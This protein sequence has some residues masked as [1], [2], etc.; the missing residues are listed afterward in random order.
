MRGFP[1]GTE[2]N[3]ELWIF[4][5]NWLVFHLELEE[6]LAPLL[7]AVYR[8]GPLRLASNALPRD[9]LIRCADLC[10]KQKVLS[11]S[12]ANIKCA[13][14]ILILQDLSAETLDLWRCLQPLTSVLAKEKIWYQW[15]AYTWVQ[16]LHKGAWPIDE[17]LES[18]AHLLKNLGL[19]V[20]SD[21]PT[22]DSSADKPPWQT[23][24][25]SDSAFNTYFIFLYLPYKLNVIW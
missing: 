23:A 19:E 9:I 3:M 14:K 10:M 12:R 20:S 22:S 15:S 21:F 11:T 1:K 25:R 13:Y 8:L 24:W 5:S 2:E 17:D 16:V 6:G 7:E 4:I 18:G